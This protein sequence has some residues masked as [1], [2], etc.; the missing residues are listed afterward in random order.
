MSRAGGV[1]I[2]ELLAQQGWVS[3]LA[4]Q[5]AG[6]E[7][8]DVAQDTWFA[9]LR[10]PPEQGR[11]IRP[12]LTTVVRNMVRLRWRDGSRRTRR[13]EAFQA[14]GPDQV[15]GVDQVYE[16][17]ELQRF[18]A[19]QVMALEEPLRMVVVLR[20]V[21]GLDASRIAELI[22][23]P[24]GTVRWR[25]KTALD[26]LRRSLDARSG[27]DWRVWTAVLAP[28][29]PAVSTLT[30]GAVLMANA[31]LRVSL[32]SVLVLLLAAIPATVL[33]RAR[34]GGPHGSPTA[35]A[36]WNDRAFVGGGV[37]EGGP[38]QSPGSSASSV[39]GSLAGLVQQ[40]GGGR[41]EGAVVV[42]TA[43]PS[44]AGAGLERDTCLAA[45]AGALR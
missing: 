8:E 1:P 11:P 5:L 25:L 22:G 9:A 6:A 39:A 20:Y 41:V 40:M 7:G 2:D 42:A 36:D 45:Q 12:W 38:G 37:R 17:L 31:K 35:G 34:S 24:A 23:S 10:S 32:V 30:T 14:L 27:G 43:V 4:R 13:E 33:W 19:E 21:E 3:R 28:A 16:R 18:L 44:G 26:R 29:I 15:E